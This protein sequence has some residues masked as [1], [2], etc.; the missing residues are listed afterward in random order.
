M[1][2]HA[3][4]FGPFSVLVAAGIALT[5]CGGGG[6]SP[7]SGGAAAGKTTVELTATKAGDVLSNANGRT[8]YVSDQE[9]G[10]VLCTSGACNAIWHPLTV[11]GGTT[12]T[13]PPR[14]PA[15]LTTL[16]RP[17]GSTQVAFK[18]KPLYTFSFDH[19]AG[20]LGGEGQV[21]SFDGTKFTWHAASIGRLT[22][23]PSTDQ[24][25]TAPANPYSY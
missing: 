4:F 20:Q 9:S 18:G 14:L 23:S 17:D 21:D 19:S 7:D 5:A 16:S 2:K 11:A 15:G 13:A 10:K 24:P 22:Q 1:H 25:S 8:L 6:S 3:S 12:P